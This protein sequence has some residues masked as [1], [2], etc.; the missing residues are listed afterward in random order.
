MVILELAVAL[1]MVGLI[2]YWTIRLLTRPQDERRPIS[3]AGQWRAAHYDVEGSTRVVLQKI[4]PTGVNVLDEHV[5]ATIRIDDPEYDVKFL[6]A[7]NS[8]RERRALFETE[9]E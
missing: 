9:E 1:G 7:M 5:L 3:R 6:T 4:S 2:F 8:A